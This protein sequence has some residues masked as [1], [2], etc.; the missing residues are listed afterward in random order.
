MEI[1][2]VVLLTPGSSVVLLRLGN[3]RSIWSL[4]ADLHG[5]KEKLFSFAPV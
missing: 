5:V 4:P 3:F 2:S 1:N